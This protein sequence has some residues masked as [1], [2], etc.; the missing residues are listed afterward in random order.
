M[1]AE[2][3]KAIQGKVGASVDGFWGPRS[4]EACQGYL[5]G[6]M[7]R[8]SN[9]WPGTDQA[10]LTRFYGEAGDESRLVMIELPGC[11][12]YEGIPVRRARVNGRCAESL[13]RVLEALALSHAEVLGEFAGVFNDRA[14]RGGSTPSL[15]ARG[16]AIDLMPDSN[17]NRMHWPVAAEMPF[18]V[19]EAFAREGW[20]SAGAFW[21]RDAMHFQATR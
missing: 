4:I 16:A 10:S 15:H 19:M 7:E 18:E 8:S 3:I 9:R 2:K 6:L 14:M 17:G 21:G 11:M 5:R 12:R 20:L 13:S 1:N